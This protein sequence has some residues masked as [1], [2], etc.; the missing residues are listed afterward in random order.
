MAELANLQATEELIAQMA[1]QMAER[2]RQYEPKVTPPKEVQYAIHTLLALANLTLLV[3]E[4]VRQ[5]TNKTENPDD[6]RLRAA[7][8]RLVVEAWL[9]N[10]RIA[11]QW[12]P[13]WHKQGG[14]PLSGLDKL[15][16]LERG[17]EE[18]H[19]QAEQLSAVAHGQPPPLSPEGLQSIQS[20]VQFIRDHYDSLFK[21]LAE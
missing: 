7:K 10:V 16:D 4:A 6:V 19:S 5:R 17:L 3:W 21:R 1:P 15:S 20:T 8:M 12:I 11:I 2:L 14:A 18:A 9:A 13:Q